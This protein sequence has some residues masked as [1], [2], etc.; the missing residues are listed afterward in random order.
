MTNQLDL[1]IPFRS[2]MLH[3]IGFKFGNGRKGLDY[4]KAVIINDL[5]KYADQRKAVGPAALPLPQEERTKALDTRCRA[6]PFLAE[7]QRRLR[8]IPRRSLRV[9][10]A[11]NILP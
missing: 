5:S 9:K 1:F 6:A 4:T 8:H 11:A 2:E 7:T 10:R 3:G